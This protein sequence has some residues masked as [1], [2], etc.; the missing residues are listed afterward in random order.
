MELHFIYINGLSEENTIHFD[1]IEERNEYMKNG[2]TF[3]VVNE[4]FYPPHSHLNIRIDTDDVDLNSTVNYLSFEYNN[5]WYYYF[6]QS[7]RY[8][9]ENVIEI[10]LKMDT[11]M[12][13]Y[14]D[15]NIYSGI[16]ER[17]TIS[18]WNNSE[19][20][21][22]YIQENIS[23]SNNFKEHYTSKD[24]INTDVVMDIIQ[25]FPG[26]T[27][28]IFTIDGKVSSLPYGCICYFY[29]KDG[30]INNIQYKGSTYDNTLAGN[31]YNNAKTLKIISSVPIEYFCKNY[32]INYSSSTGIRTLEIYNNDGIG[33][34]SLT[35]SKNIY[36]KISSINYDTLLGINETSIPSYFTKNTSANNNRSITYCPYLSSP[37]YRRICYGE[38]SNLGLVQ[39]QKYS[40]EDFVLKYCYDISDGS[41]I[42]CINNIINPYSQ[43]IN[44]YSSTDL[45][46]ATDNWNAYYSRNKNSTFTGMAVSGI[47]TALGIASGNVSSTITGITGLAKELSN[48]SDI[49]NAPNQIQ[50]SNTVLNS[51][52][53]GASK[54][55]IIYK[56]VEDIVQC[57]NYFENYGMKINKTVNT[58]S[59]STIYHRHYFDYVKFSDVNI[60]A[61][62]FMSKEIENDYI[63]RLKSGLRL[64][65][66]KNK[67]TLGVY[68]KDNVEE[69]W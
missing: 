29:C 62:T 19:I 38:M 56:N 45:P 7:I 54:P 30:T 60:S 39:S 26:D 42:Y 63:Q 33:F 1:T 16:L 18:R 65:H 50:V 37:S 57:M 28:T 13:Y 23:Q 43:I 59:L 4:T 9:N 5:R 64:W 15:I 68:N 48:V 12:T 41:R 53:T 22:D 24:I 40:N 3:K 25:A 10:S 8:V 21:R 66:Y 32:A 51:L 44:C 6:I 14:F 49:Q 34:S 69:S 52:L 58:R 35:E 27:A 17:N 47:T 2:E 31:L 20:N 55:I 11:I 61:E 46:I 67:I 36:F